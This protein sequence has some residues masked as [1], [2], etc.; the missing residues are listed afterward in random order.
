[1]AVDTRVSPYKRFQQVLLPNPETDRAMF[2]RV[3]KD[4]ALKAASL[5]YQRVL[6]EGDFKTIHDTVLNLAS[7]LAKDETLAGYNIRPE[8]VQT[9]FER[10]VGPSLNQ[11]PEQ[12]LQ[13]PQEQSG[14][15][16]GFVK[17]LGERKTAP[18]AGGGNSGDSG[19]TGAVRSLQ[20]QKFMDEFEE[21]LKDPDE[22]TR[23]NK[24]RNLLDRMEAS[25]LLDNQVE[26]VREHIVHTERVQDALKNAKTQAEKDAILQ[27]LNEDILEQK[28]KQ[29]LALKKDSE[30]EGATESG[31][32]AK[33]ERETTDIKLTSHLFDATHGAGFDQDK[34][35]NAFRA[36]MNH[37]MNRVNGYSILAEYANQQQ[38]LMLLQ[39][40][41]EIGDAM[42]M[43]QRQRIQAAQIITGR[44]QQQQRQQ[45]QRG[46]NGF[47]NSLRGLGKQQAKKYATKELKAYLKKIA[48]QALTKNPYFWAAVGIVIAVIVAVVIIILIVVVIV[49]AIQQFFSSGTNGQPAQLGPT[50]NPS[51]TCVVAL[52][53]IGFNVTGDLV[54]YKDPYGK[55]K[56]AYETLAFI[57]QPP[58][59]YL[60]LLKTTQSS[61]TINF[62][63]GGC[64]GHA[65]TNGEVNLYGFGACG[66]DVAKFM[67]IHEL[68]H[69]IAFRNPNLYNKFYNEFPFPVLLFYKLPTYNCELDYG[70][71]GPYPGECFADTLGEYVL[72]KTYRN[73]V[74]GLPVYFEHNFSSFPRL[75]APFY[76]FAKDNVYNG[77]EF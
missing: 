67:L 73:T 17:G 63:A 61:I 72:Y 24:I 3:Q 5:E 29:A 54:L 46:G 53:N 6:R 28:R 23:D 8:D 38:A 43:A 68:G 34:A 51:N 10:E 49:I 21:A 58:S 35:R 74:S 19:A 75:F 12:Q 14:V 41:N 64:A 70:P 36:A 45:S 27:K 11:Q 9:D 71:H 20:E 22:R 7:Q 66:T 16:A 65:S 76:N 69:E 48:I 55:A 52:H 1:M 57:S 47:L 2:D 40:R 18:S 33:A 32:K 44:L 77:L 15:V 62:S 42:E 26:V 25:K 13:Q 39:L 31:R 60:Q 4:P 59:K 50:C 56:L 37:R 30:E